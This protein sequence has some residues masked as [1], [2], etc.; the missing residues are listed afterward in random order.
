MS[1]EGTRPHADATCDGGD[2][3]CGSGLLLIIRGAITPLPAGGVLEVKS[4][5][6]SVKEDLP[7]WCRMVGH[8][9]LG[10]FPG[11]GK[12]THYFI[13][14]Q[15]ADDALARDLEKA[16]DFVWTTR[17]KWT[18]GMQ[19]KAFVRNH[20]FAVGQPAS[21]DTQD[22]APSAVEYLLAALGGCLAAGFA[23]RASQRG[24]EIRNLEVSLKAQ[25]DNVLVFLGIESNGHPG[26]RRIEGT[27]YVDA[28]EDDP[29]LDALWKETL[30]RSPVTQSL[31]RQV[32]VDVQLRRV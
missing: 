22:A 19:T 9:M 15:S 12:N 21:F 13:R 32:P 24:I 26:M 4:R 5:E 30:E 3:D 27:L 31:V 23:W 29:V 11:E 28:D 17:V 7:A 1:S 2:L 18:S 6:I 25:A 8:A 20:A 14:K 16:R 10:S